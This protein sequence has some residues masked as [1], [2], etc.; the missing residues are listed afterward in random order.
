MLLFLNIRYY[1]IQSISDTNCSPFHI[2]FEGHMISAKFSE[3][4][5]CILQPF[6]IA[7]LLC[8]LDHNINT[9]EENT[10]FIILKYIFGI[11]K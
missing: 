3:I 8:K 10:V 2:Q 6:S 11:Y 9:Y 1:L 4:I 7:G 5:I